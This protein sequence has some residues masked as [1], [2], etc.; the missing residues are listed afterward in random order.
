MESISAEEAY[1]HLGFSRF[2]GEGEFV[3]AP[4]WRSLQETDVL[5][6]IRQR[7]LLRR[8]R[9]GQP[10]VDVGFV[11]GTIPALNLGKDELERLLSALTEGIARGCRTIKDWQTF[12]LA[13]RQAG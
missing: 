13:Q 2:E 11:V 5:E 12:K 7:Y 3:E 9:A 8:D 1:T 10:I 4:F 6:E